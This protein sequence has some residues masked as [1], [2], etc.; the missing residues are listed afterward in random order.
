MKR[1]YAR[2]KFVILNVIYRRCNFNFKINNFLDNLYMIKFILENFYRRPIGDFANQV[3]IKFSCLCMSSF[4]FL[5]CSLYLSLFEG[6]EHNYI[7]D[8][9]VDDHSWSCYTFKGF[10]QFVNSAYLLESCCYC[11]CYYWVFIILY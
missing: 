3:C 2:C 6:K 10:S 11:Y 8:S 5:C 1:T 4:W 7:G 9:L